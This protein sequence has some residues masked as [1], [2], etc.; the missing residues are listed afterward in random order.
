MKFRQRRRPGGNRRYL[1]HKQE[2]FPGADKVLYNLSPML[3]LKTS[4]W[5]QIAVKVSAKSSEGIGALVSEIDAHNAFLKTSTES[6]ASWAIEKLKRELTDRISDLVTSD[7][8]KNL[9]K[10][11][12]FAVALSNN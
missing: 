10:I 2:R 6:S 4:G 3:S 7:L 8:A 9:E 5:K 11:P 1:R 12:E